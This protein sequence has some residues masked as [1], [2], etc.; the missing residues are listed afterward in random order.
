MSLFSCPRS[1]STLVMDQREACHGD[2]SSPHIMGQGCIGGLG[3]SRERR[4]V[5]HRRGT[6]L[7]E[8]VLSGLGNRRLG[9][10]QQVRIW[11]GGGREGGGGSDLGWRREVVPSSPRRSGGRSHRRR[12]HLVA[13][14]E[15]VSSNPLSFFRKY[16]D[17][18]NRKWSHCLHQCLREEGGEWNSLLKRT[19]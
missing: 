3:I 8:I 13:G 15:F 4:L 10:G 12:E 19:T 7:V 11:R 16:Q 1:S 5:G 17:S 6:V 18:R 14:S 2:T 9:R